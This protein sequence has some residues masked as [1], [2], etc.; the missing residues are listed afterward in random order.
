M[1]PN[2]TDATT[3]TRNGP[4]ARVTRRDR[5]LGAATL[6]ATGAAAFGRSLGQIVGFVIA[7]VALALLAACVGRAVDALSDRV[8]AAATGILQSAL[9]NLPE[10]LILIFALRS[11]LIAVVQATI[12]GSI[13]ANVALVL[14]IA[15]IAGGVRNGVQRFPGSGARD[16]GLSLL[17]GVAALAVPSVTILLHVPAASHE[18]TLSVIVSVVL[19]IA[20]G[21][22]LLYTLRP[23]GQAGER[24]AGPPTAASGSSGRAATE[25]GT[26]PEAH[27]PLWLALAVLGVTGVLAALVS[28]WFVAALQPAITALHINET[29][30]GLVIVAIAGNAVENFVGV[31]LALRDQPE[32]ALQV[33]LQSPLQIAMFVAPLVLLLAPLLGAGGFTLVL[34]PLLLVS[35]VASAMLAVF[36]T[37][38]GESTWY[39]GAV[40]IALYALLAA[41]FWWG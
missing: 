8:S 10:L 26:A 33:V 41:S 9:G 19:L 38:D 1:T 39:E 5:I 18:R 40:L 27:W 30:A 24:E 32:H 17:L 31:Q 4:L 11:G 34:P 25:A 22:S 3:P 35:L 28:D 13:L 7:A 16:L 2:A 6:L 14:G 36:I 23:G 12:V 37:L 21:L 29:F 20:F 15:F